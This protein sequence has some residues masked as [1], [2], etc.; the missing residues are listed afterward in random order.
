MKKQKSQ[1]AEVGENGGRVLQ[2]SRQSAG[3]TYR[4][5]GEDKVDRCDDR[6][7][8]HDPLTHS[9]SRWWQCLVP[10]LRC[11]DR[12]T[13]TPSSRC[14]A[15]SLY[16]CN[17][18]NYQFSCEKHTHLLTISKRPGPCII[19]IAQL[20]G[21]LY[22]SPKLHPGPCCSV[23]MRRCTNTQTHR[24]TSAWPIYISR[25]LWLRRNVNN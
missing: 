19:N 14:P 5:Q 6:H 3:C 21:T 2:M 16:V 7:S 8:S 9:N 10:G 25:R 18:E 12:L 15:A 11:T 22:H 24:H 4:S 23:G 1:C 13:N 20:E 17:R